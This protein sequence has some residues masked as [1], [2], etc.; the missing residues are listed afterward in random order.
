MIDLK[1]HIEKH[2]IEN[3]LFMTPMR[4]VNQIMFIRYKSSS[5][6]EVTV[7]CRIDEDR[8]KIEDNYKITLKC[9][10]PQFGKEHYYMSDL[11]QL[12]DQGHIE[13]YTLIPCKNI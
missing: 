2:G 8:Y 11:A 1:G 10:Y 4:P 6:P 7:P 5:D 3:C 12:I 13:L 9:T